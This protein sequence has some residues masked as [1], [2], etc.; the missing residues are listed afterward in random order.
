MSA[1]EVAYELTRRGDVGCVTLTG[2]NPL[3]WDCGALIDAIRETTP[4]VTVACETQGSLYK[5]WLSKVD[6]VICSPKPP[7]AGQ[8]P[9]D[10]AVLAKVLRTPKASALKIVVSNDADLAWV[11]GLQEQYPSVPLYLQPCRDPNDTRLESLVQQYKWLVEEVLKQRRPNVSVLPQL[12]V[13]LW[14]NR[15]DA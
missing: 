10:H 11:W 4:G 8:P 9:V 6:L 5:D 14:G 3:L 1:A 13:W 12:H 7:S 2:G 15:R